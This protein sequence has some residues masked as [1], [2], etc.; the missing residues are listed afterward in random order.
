MVHSGS[1]DK[2]GKAVNLQQKPQI[3]LL[4][5][6]ISFPTDKTN[7]TTK[8]YFTLCVTFSQGWFRAS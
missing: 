7:R 4:T 8:C 5:H 2:V 1:C 3:V 6:K